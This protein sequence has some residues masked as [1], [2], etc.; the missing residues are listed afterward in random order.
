MLVSFVNKAIYHLPKL[1]IYMVLIWLNK[2]LSEVV[3]TSLKYPL[4]YL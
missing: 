1:I 2:W 3:Q 4:E